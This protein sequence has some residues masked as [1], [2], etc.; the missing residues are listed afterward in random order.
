MI[1]ANMAK[2]TFNDI[3]TTPVKELKKKYKLNDRQ[4]ETQVR[5]HLYGARTDERN[6]MYEKIYNKR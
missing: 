3:M 4:F 5:D 1:G 2:V 6:R